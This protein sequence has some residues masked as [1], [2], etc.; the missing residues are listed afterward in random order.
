MYT[1]VN[2]VS[3]LVFGDERSLDAEYSSIMRQIHMDPTPA[4]EASVTVFVYWKS[5]LLVDAIL[6]VIYSDTL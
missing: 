5:K 6:K 3:C 4:Q 2:F 1:Y